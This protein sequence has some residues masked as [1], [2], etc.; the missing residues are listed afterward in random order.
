[1]VKMK[2]IINIKVRTVFIILALYYGYKLLGLFAIA[3]ASMS[4]ADGGNCSIGLLPI[5]KEIAP[6]FAYCIGAIM[7]YFSTKINTT[8]EL[9]K[10]GIVMAFNVH[11]LIVI[12]GFGM[13]LLSSFFYSPLFY[14]NG[15]VS[16]FYRFVLG[17]LPLILLITIFK[18]A[19]FGFKKMVR[20]STES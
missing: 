13:L 6:F 20:S 18:E 14:Y 10:N 19:Y 17:I 11:L 3:G 2:K 5:L 9:V 12:C 15:P 16:I 8:K 4:C 1:M 7:I